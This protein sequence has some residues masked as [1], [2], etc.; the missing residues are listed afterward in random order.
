M[1][2]PEAAR[3]LFDPAAAV[4]WGQRMG[5]ELIRLPDTMAQW[6]EG[7]EIFLGVAQRMEA[8][9]ASAEQL[10]KQLHDAGLPEQAERLSKL[11][12]DLTAAMASGGANLG[13]Q[14]VEETRRN[15]AALVKL[16]AERPIEPDDK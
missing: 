2:A 11:W 8:V 1:T 7:V 9:T 12:L 15:V 5:Q 13:E 4:R 14:V 6:R 16:F 10:L 3:P